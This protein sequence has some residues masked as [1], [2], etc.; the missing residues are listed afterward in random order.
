MN[1]Q[2]SQK[3]SPES[4]TKDAE[5]STTSNAVLTMPDGRKIELPVLL[6]AFGN[7]IFVDV[8]KLQPAHSVCTF[9]SGFSS[10]AACR[11]AITYIDGEKG[12]LLYRG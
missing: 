9:D 8:Q 6:D 5:V 3:M 1:T 12:V 10:T 7:G 11:S 4:D 2:S